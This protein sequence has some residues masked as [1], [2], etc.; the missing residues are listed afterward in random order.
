[1][2]Y[3]ASGALEQLNESD[4][5]KETQKLLR[6]YIEASNKADEPVKFS[7]RKKKQIKAAL[8]VLEINTVIIPDRI[9]NKRQY[10]R[11]PVAPIYSRVQ[12]ID[13]EGM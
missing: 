12:G 6:S 8:D 9:L 4:L 11:F 1:M 3:Y 13:N 7:Y 10:A 2:W 5:D